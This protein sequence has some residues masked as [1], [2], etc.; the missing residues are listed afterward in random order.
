MSNICQ[1]R[2]IYCIKI[3]NKIA[4]QFWEYCTLYSKLIISMMIWP[5][6]FLL[7]SVLDHGGSYDW[8]STCSEPEWPA[9]DTRGCL[10][11]RGRNS[12]GYGSAPHWF[13][14]HWTLLL[15]TAP[16]LSGQQG[17]TP[18]A[19]TVSFLYNSINSY[20]SFWTSLKTLAVALHHV[21]VSHKH[22]W[23]ENV[24][25]SETKWHKS[26]LVCVKTLNGCG[27]TVEAT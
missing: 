23:N 25:L 14:S 26:Q 20:L 24:L 15:A 1:T 7:L 6:R 11:H 17:T 3:I 12:A 13:N 16:T 2:Q 4:V 27:E 10:S 18:H 22:I 19:W 9:G 5:K 21:S 8:T